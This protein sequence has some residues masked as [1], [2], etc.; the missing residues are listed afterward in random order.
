MSMNTEILDKMKPLKSSP[1]PMN[2]EILNK[3][4]TLK[5]MPKA[6]LG[7]GLGVILVLVALLVYVFW[8]P[9]KEA[10]VGLVVRDRAIS[11]AYGTVRVE[12]LEERIVSSRVPGVISEVLVKEGQ[13]VEQGDLLAVI[14]DENLR[15]EL[16]TRKSAYEIARQ[17]LDLGPEG[18]AE[19]NSKI[20]ELDVDRALYDEQAISE[21]EYNR[22]KSEVEELQKRIETQ[23]LTLKDEFTTAQEAFE[24]LQVQVEQ[25]KIKSS[26]RGIILHEYAQVG[27]II[28]ELDPLFKIGSKEIQVKALI[29]EEDVGEV[30]AGK[31]AKISLYAYPNKNFDAVVKEVL[32]QPVQQD[33]GV[34]L[35]MAST[36]VN[37]K[38][39]MS[40]EVN[41]ILGERDNALIVPTR[42][43]RSNNK[44]YVVSNKKVELREVKQGYRSID[45]VEIRQGLEEG[46]LV[47]L[48]DHDLFQ[49]GDRVKPILKENN[50]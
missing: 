50:P 25:G 39:G 43:L 19:L 21:V 26:L 5:S 31:K 23:R 44:I 29:K 4:K 40:G 17:K 10:E 16:R 30:A 24:G 3:I 9:K 22:K 15:A 20:K 1:K 47:I 49:T 28:S 34:L 41:I 8:G 48:S 7:V 6:Y 36:P 45:K 27:E 11:V 37:I 18:Q 32:P 46:E 12:P 38:N 35:D 42:A 2:T 33:Y 13:W 14:G